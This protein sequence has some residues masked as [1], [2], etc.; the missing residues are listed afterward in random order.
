MKPICIVAGGTGGHV[1]PAICLALELHVQKTPF[2]FLTDKR[3]LK[4]V[5]PHQNIITPIVLPMGSKKQGLIGFIAFLM[6]LFLSFIKSIPLVLR[7]E[8]IIGFSGFPTFPTLLAGWFLRRPLFAHEQNAVLGK[9]NRLMGPSFKKIFTSTDQVFRLSFSSNENKIKAIQDKIDF[10]GMPV[11]KDIQS[12]GQK[13]YEIPRNESPIRLLIIGGSQG[14]RVFSTV[15]PKAL[16]LLPLNMQNCLEIVHQVRNADKEIATENYKFL[17]SESLDMKPFIN[18]MARAYEKAH[19]VISRSGASS[20][21]EI[22]AVGRPSILVPYPHAADNH[23]EANADVITKISGGWKISEKDFS[24]ETLSS[25]LGDL[26]SNPKKLLVA[27]QLVKKKCLKSS[28]K[29]LVQKL[30]NV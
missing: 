28:I 26:F 18:D 23:Q 9:V 17:K 8:K 19:L 15:V 30:F 10:V 20:L 6:D 2:I 13:P 1:F 27:S 12:V 11:R 25:L 29:S 3:G 21:A 22:M 5:I 24:A 14:A 7:S 16:S 4:Y